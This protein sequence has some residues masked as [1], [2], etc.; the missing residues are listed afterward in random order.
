MFWALAGL[1]GTFA[2]AGFGIAGANSQAAAEEARLQQE[3]LIAAFNAELIETEKIINEAAAV[4][5]SNDRFREFWFAN[6]ANQAMMGGAM[7]RDISG[8]DRSVQAFLNRNKETTGR[9]QERIAVQSNLESLGMDIQAA[10]ERRRSRDL[11]AGAEVA[12]A[13][14]RAAGRARA[15]TTILGGLMNFG[16]TMFMPSRGP[17]N[18]T[19]L[20]PIT[21]SLR[22][23]PRPY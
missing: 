7:G 11:M 9:D 22:P 21:S 10:S 23:L 16:E 18:T 1:F 15:F 17:M 20:S 2:Q 8:E 3:G 12:G 6:A 14:I 19:S 13:N 5:A 4:Q